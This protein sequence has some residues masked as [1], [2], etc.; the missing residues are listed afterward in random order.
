[1]T[2]TADKTTAI[3][4]IE[5]TIGEVETITLDYTAL[6]Y[7]DTLTAKDSH[8][9]MDDDD[10]GLTLSGW[11]VNASEIDPEGRKT[12]AV[13]KALQV[14]VDATGASAGTYTLKAL[15]NT[16]NGRTK[17]LKVVIVVRE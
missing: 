2:A 15:A 9:W 1:M 17:G 16:S 7:D 3:G 4:V 6:L 11:V 14:E 10:G 12:I 5:L 8:Q 13:G